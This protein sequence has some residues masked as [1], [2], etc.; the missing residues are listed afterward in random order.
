M[1]RTA[2]LAVGFLL[3]GALLSRAA[4]SGPKIKEPYDSRAFITLQPLVNKFVLWELAKAWGVKI[5]PV[6]V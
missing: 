6:G 5:P 3:A 2:W 1:V 4:F